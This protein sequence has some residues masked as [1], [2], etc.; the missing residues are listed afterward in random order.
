MKHGRI[1]ETQTSRYRLGLGIMRLIYN[2]DMNVL[3]L[4]SIINNHLNTRSLSVFLSLHQDVLTDCLLFTL[5]DILT[6]E[7]YHADPGYY[8]YSCFDIII[9]CMN[10]KDHKMTPL[11]VSEN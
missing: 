7:S 3:P 6:T 11:W 5:P 1:T 2:P 8:T 9:V 4:F 10:P